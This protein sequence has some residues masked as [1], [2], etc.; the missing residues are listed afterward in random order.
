MSLTHGAAGLR[1]RNMEVA[2]YRHQHHIVLNPT[3]QL[4]QATQVRSRGGG[5]FEGIDDARILTGAAEGGAQWSNSNKAI[6]DSSLC[7]WFAQST[8]NLL[9]DRTMATVNERRK[10]GQ[11]W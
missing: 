2:C 8:M 6:V 1:R 7:P 9:E 4:E 11:V 10:Y 3:T 5:D